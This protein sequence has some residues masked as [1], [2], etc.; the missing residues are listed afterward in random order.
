MAYIYVPVSGHP[1]T[2][3]SFSLEQITKFCS[4][5]IQKLLEYIWPLYHISKWCPSILMNC[6]VSTL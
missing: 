2:Q 6:P 3:E 5:D 4:N 1:V